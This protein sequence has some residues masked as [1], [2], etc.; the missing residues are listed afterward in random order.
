MDVH[1]NQGHECTLTDIKARKNILDM[2]KRHYNEVPEN[3]QE[4][5]LASA[6]I[7]TPMNKK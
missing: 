3:L 7:Q 2:D 5:R 1:K 6:L 4:A